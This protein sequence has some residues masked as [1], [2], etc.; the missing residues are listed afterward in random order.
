M[1]ENPEEHLPRLWGTLKFS[2]QYANTARGKHRMSAFS[3]Q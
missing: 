2:V 1:G 3:L